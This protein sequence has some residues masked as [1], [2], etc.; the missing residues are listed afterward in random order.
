MIRCVSSSHRMI[1]GIS[2][3][4]HCIVFWIEKARGVQLSRG[5]ACPPFS[6]PAAFNSPSLPTASSLRPPHSSD[7]ACSVARLDATSL[8]LLRPPHSSL[9]QSR[10]THGPSP[11]APAAASPHHHTRSAARRRLAWSALSP[12]QD[13]VPPL[14]ARPLPHARRATTSSRRRHGGSRHLKRR[15]RLAGPADREDLVVPVCRDARPAGPAPHRDSDVS[16]LSVG[17]R[18][19]LGGL[20]TSESPARAP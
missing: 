8:S 1:R 12:R 5:P 7:T 16:L 13:H 4:H 10:V 2:S 17:L 6:P 3:S 20:G 15:D 18:A 19:I 9:S 11:K 14:R